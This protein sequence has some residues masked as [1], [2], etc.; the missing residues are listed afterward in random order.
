MNYLQLNMCKR[1]N[2][3]DYTHYVL[4]ATIFTTTQIFEKNKK[5][6]YLVFFEI[7]LVAKYKQLIGELCN[8]YI[9]LKRLLTR[10]MVL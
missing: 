4:W 7:L 1:K 9:I 10:N 8:D 5:Q 2:F 3:F 6:D